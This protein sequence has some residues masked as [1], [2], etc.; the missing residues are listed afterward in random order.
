MT[1]PQDRYTHLRTNATTQKQATIDRLSQAI[2]ELEAEGRPVSTF[3]IREVSGL[4]YMAYY[5]NR[6]AYQLFQDHSTHLR[7]EREKEDV[8]LQSTNSRAKGKKRKWQ[9]TPRAAKV[10]PRDPLLDYKRPR[11][12]E[13]LYEARAERDEAKRQAK[14]ERFEAERR[15]QAE[16]AELKQRYHKLLQEHTQC[17]VKIARLEAELEKFRTFMERYRSSLEREEQGS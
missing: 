8:K 13:L 11:L 6:E 12:V 7:K 10:A 14:E 9:E 5:R 17:G 16:Q 4:D 15:A 3:T 1:P 2:K